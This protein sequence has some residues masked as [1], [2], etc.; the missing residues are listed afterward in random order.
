MEEEDT[1]KVVKVNQI[2][3]SGNLAFPL[4]FIVAVV[5]FKTACTKSEVPNLEFAC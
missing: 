3:L 1:C 5:I 4:P 2:L